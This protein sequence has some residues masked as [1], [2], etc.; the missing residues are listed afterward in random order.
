MVGAGLSARFAPPTMRGNH[1]YHGIQFLL[2]FPETKITT[3]KTNKQTN[4]QK[5]DGCLY[6]NKTLKEDMEKKSSL[7]LC[8]LFRFRDNSPRNAGRCA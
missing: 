1:L 6:G 3:K 2:S 7:H 5:K 8:S 4:K